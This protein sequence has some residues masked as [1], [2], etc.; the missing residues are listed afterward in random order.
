KTLDTRIAPRRLVET[1][2][3]P[4]QPTR[5]QAPSIAPGMARLEI[6]IVESDGRPAR[7]RVFDLVFTTGV[8]T[9]NEL[10]EEDHWIGMTLGAPTTCRPGARRIEYTAVERG[11][12]DDGVVVLEVPADGP[13]HLRI[14]EAPAGQKQR[15]MAGP[16]KWIAVIP[17]QAMSGGQTRR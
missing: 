6:P 15:F 9:E 3:E 1:E 17:Y 8:K 2:T 4:A 11:L 14:R 7:A 16:I 12:D 13:G 10:A 5:K